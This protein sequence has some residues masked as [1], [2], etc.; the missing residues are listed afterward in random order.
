MP[1]LGEVEERYI[2][3]ERLDFELK[4]SVL[5]AEHV[6]DDLEFQLLFVELRAH[7]AFRQLLQKL[8]IQRQQT[9]LIIED[10]HAGNCGIRDEVDFNQLL[11]RATD[12]GKLELPGRVLLRACYGR[13]ARAQRRK[14]GAVCFVL[15]LQDERQAQPA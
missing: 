15:D 6:A 5:G 4:F 11:V 2:R 12:I 9:R 13:C 14:P 1:V 3:T 7:L 10:E 8:R